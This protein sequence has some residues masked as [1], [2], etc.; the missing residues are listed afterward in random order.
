MINSGNYPADVSVIRIVPQGSLIESDIVT[1]S[2][3]TS[4]EAS[5]R[6]TMPLGTV[7][8]GQ[9]VH[10]TYF[11]RINDDFMGRS[12]QGSSTALYL[13]TIDGRRYSGESR[14]NSYKLNIE[15]I[16]E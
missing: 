9:T 4:S 10:L 12:L 14:S 2:T 13:F 15:E 1:V 3:L 6:G 16:S 8:A 5:Y 7:Q 11:V